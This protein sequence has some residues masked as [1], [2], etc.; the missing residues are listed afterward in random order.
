MHFC[1]KDNIQSSAMKELRSENR[2]TDPKRTY[3]QINEL[4]YQIF[5]GERF[6]KNPDAN[7]KAN[8]TNIYSKF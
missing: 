8:L 6:L 4:T 1:V 7:F 5:D 3:D 2:L